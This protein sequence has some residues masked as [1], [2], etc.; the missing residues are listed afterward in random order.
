MSE[1]KRKISGKKMGR[2]IREADKRMDREI[3]RRVR[4]KRRKE[5]KTLE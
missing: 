2:I 4:Q 5:N 3:A 1:K